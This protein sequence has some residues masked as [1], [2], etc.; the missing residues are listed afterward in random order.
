[1]DAKLEA[2]FA[3]KYADE[4][5]ERDL[6]LL[7]LGLYDKVYSPDNEPSQE[8][9]CREGEGEDARY[10]KPVP[11]EVTPGEYAAL[12][13]YNS[14]PAPQYRNRVAS[15]LSVLAWIVYIG[16]FLSGFAQFLDAQTVF[17]GIAAGF[18]MWILSFFSGSV[19]LGFSQAVKL[20]GEIK[21][22]LE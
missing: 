1:M 6:L 22:K 19:M 5:E 13:K 10:F 16:G 17:V 2:Y 20:L 21:N 12:R 7:R 3:A 15:L 14:E 18:T 9:Y 8:Y 4:K 11:I